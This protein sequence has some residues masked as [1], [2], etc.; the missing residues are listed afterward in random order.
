MKTFK[1]I[2]RLTKPTEFDKA[3]AQK[4]SSKHMAKIVEILKRSFR[5][6][7]PH[8]YADEDFSFGPALGAAAHQGKLFNKDLKILIA[9]SE[10]EL[11]RLQVKEKSKKIK[12]LNKGF[13]DLEGPSF[14]PTP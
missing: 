2:K 3:V 14:D 13:G 5:S 11:L 9:I 10:K 7:D 4:F 6:E 1:K 12:K 8:S